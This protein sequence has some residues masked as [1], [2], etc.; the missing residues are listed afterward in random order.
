VVL[1]NDTARELLGGQR[2][3]RAARLHELTAVVTE[4]L[5]PALAPGI[6]A[7]GDPTRIPLDGRMLQAQAAAITIRPDIKR[8]GTVIVLRDITED[9]MLEQ[10]R[11]TLLQTLSEQA[12]APRA[13]RAYESL[14]AL[15]QE[16]ARNARTVQNVIAELR[17]LSAFE[18]RDLETGQR[19]LAIND[20]LWHI[21]AE[22][23]LL[24]KSAGIRL[25]VKFGPRGAHVLGDDR[26]L[27]WAIGNVIDNALKYSPRGATVRLSARARGES[28]EI[29]I[30][31]QGYGITP[32]DLEKVFERFFRGT[33]RDRNGKPVRKPGTGQGLF[34][35]RRV[36]EAHGGDLSLA[37]RF[38][39]GTT[40]IVRLPLT[41]EVTWEMPTAEPPVK[42]GD[43]A[44]LPDSE[45][46]T[47]RIA[48]RQFP[49]Q[50][51]D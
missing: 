50:R 20:L 29:I 17:D 34:I 23:E 3:F 9:V 37:S 21:G 18:P 2:V 45:F 12:V 43:T 11:E 16:V 44:Q 22:W 30:E 46:S 36:I 24:A 41:S 31:D 4:R 49:W 42:R 35:A 6:Y 47:V 8:I 33:P 32:K 27:R 26:R 48:P 40:A 38:G 19:P 51:D 14:S 10:R 39:A 28:A 7:L 15:A 1:I 5:G 13:P 25:R